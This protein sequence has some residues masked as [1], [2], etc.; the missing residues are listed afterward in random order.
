VGRALQRGAG[1][2]RRRPSRV[3]PRRLRDLL[4]R[5]A[6]RRIPACVEIDPTRT[7]APIRP[8]VYGQFIEHLGRCI[9]GGI[10]AEMLEDRKFFFPIT[11]AYAPHRGLE[12]TPY[13]VIGASP[14]EVVGDGVTMS[15]DDAFVGRHGPRLRAGSA[16]R[17]R[18]LGVVAG[19]EY[20][21]YVWAAGPA[22]VEVCLAWG[23][24]RDAG[25]TTRLSFAGVDYGKVAFRLTAGATTDAATFALRA[26][27][28]DVRLGPPSLMPGDHVDGMRRDTLAL[29]RELNAPLYRWPGGNFVS[30]YE[31]RD[32]IGDLDRRP[33][34]KNPAWTGVEHNDFGTDEFLRFCRELGAEPMIVVNTGFGDA[35]SAA[36]WVRYCN[37]AVRW[38]GVGNEMSGAWQLGFMQLAHYVQKHNQVAAAM[39]AV[40]PKVEL[41]AVGDLERVNTKH[42]PGQV[43]PWSQGMLEA[44]AAHM[45][46]ISEHVYGAHRAWNR[47][48]LSSVVKHVGRLRSL[49]RR[50]ADG[51]R[52]LQG[53]LPHLGGA[54]IPVALDEWNYW[55]HDYVYGELGCVYDLADALGV[56]A[57]LHE[58]FRQSDVIHMAHYAQTV[59]VLGAIKTSRTAAEIE[60]TGLVLQL[61]RAEFGEIPLKLAQ[62]FS[63]LDV[64]AALTADGGALTLGIVNP[65]EASVSLELAV[66]GARVAG[67]GVRWQ[68]GGATPQ[69]HNAPGR[70]RAVDVRRFEHDGAGKRVDVPPLSCVVLRVPLE[71]G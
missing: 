45:S 59:N 43:V 62:D 41:V 54:R 58:I 55:H 3:I 19:K 17:Q 66:D 5:S 21:G 37:G 9:Y 42:D 47:K 26:V 27:S 51:H 52:A 50:K 67:P 70:P 69:A 12:K 31:W 46:L 33:P 57:G 34:R 35:H 23:D 7:G 49:I 10:W 29:L 2:R 64:A 60:A 63:P 25:A 28:G 4:S 38:W 13:P 22:V 8:F 53:R 30:G 36:E 68:I 48:G 14:W 61:Y 16:I 32:G 71:R 6:S 44:C 20:E 65:T 40:D 24:A 56:A 15:A 39:R 1:P 18:D 11:A